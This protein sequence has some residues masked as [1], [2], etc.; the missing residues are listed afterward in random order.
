[1]ICFPIHQDKSHFLKLF[2]LPL[3][4]CFQAVVKCRNLLYERGI[5]KV[6]K[7]DVPVISVGNIVAGG[8]GKTPF[9]L[10]LAQQ[11]IP[12]G[13]V[14]FVS[15]GYLG[16]AE[17]QR[18]PLLIARGS[19]PMH[20]PAICGDEPFL[21]SKNLPEAIVVV[22]RNRVEAVKMAAK[23]GAQIV[24]L[25]DGM[26]HR[27]VHRDI[28]IVILN[29][30]DVKKGSWFLPSGFLRDE[31]RRLK[32]ADLVV[33][34]KALDLKKRVAHFTQAPIMEIDYVVKEVV[35]LDPDRKMDLKG[36]S[37]G[38]FCGIAHPDRFVKTVEN[39]GAQIVESHF[40]LDHRMM[41]PKTL[42]KFA[43]QAK[44]KG[45]VLLLCTEKDIVKIN[46]QTLSLP[47]AWVKREIAAPA[48][49]DA[50]YAMVETIKSRYL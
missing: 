11:L 4:F 22:G 37:V 30:H 13:R 27:R 42:E 41:A 25:D 12:F 15:R 16:K 19:G 23:E 3:S 38:V 31:K 7:C 26:Q 9:A 36:K 21:L 50:F 8:S 44:S 48:A 28:E 39:L 40:G 2:L 1:M 49:A 18:N 43:L 45:A 32:K 24:I 47:L 35:F 29:G 17:K 20:P 14:A 33:L 10:F 6:H 5:F 34:P 46:R